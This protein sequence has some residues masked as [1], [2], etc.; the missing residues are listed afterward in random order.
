MNKFQIPRPYLHYRIQSAHVPE[1]P[2][3]TMFINRIYRTVLLNLDAE[4]GANVIRVVMA[5]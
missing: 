1:Y 5:D 3:T 2:E 4:P